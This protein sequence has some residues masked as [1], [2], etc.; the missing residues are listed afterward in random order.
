VKNQVLVSTTLA[1]GGETVSAEF[2]APARPGK[3]TFI[4]TFPGHFNAGMQGVLVV[5]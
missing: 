5:K 1:G 3:Y 2:V 4:C